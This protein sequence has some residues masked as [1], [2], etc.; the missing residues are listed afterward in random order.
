MPTYF[1]AIHGSSATISGV[2]CL[3]IV[4]GLTISILVGS[5]LTS[6]IGYYTPFMILTAILSPIAAGLLTTLRTDQSL[7]SLIC[8]QALLGVGTGIG[9]QGPQVAV[10]T[11][12]PVSDASTGI[13]LI[14]FAQNVGPA[15]F[16]SIAQTIFTGELLSRLGGI[17]PHMDTQQL[18]SMGFSDIE[19]H[20]DHSDIP[21]V[22]DGYD[23]ALTTSFFLAVGF[24]CATIV[25]A[26][27]ME[28][29][30]VKK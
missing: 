24:A 9:Y 28:W 29:R 13:A 3:P 26:L 16:V 2:L 5:S 7:A 21:R 20:V 6:A 30:S 25:G 12:L 27:G 23:M 8:Y 15:I 18:T 10:Q 14:I 22:L 17:L 1:Q 4:V 19:R 11:V